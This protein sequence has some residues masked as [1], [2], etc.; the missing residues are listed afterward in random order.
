MVLKQKR[1]KQ[2][3]YINH[4]QIGDSHQM[5]DKR[6]LNLHGDGYNDSESQSTDDSSSLTELS[7]LSVL[8]MNRD[9]LSKI[10]YDA[11]I[12]IF[13]QKKRSELI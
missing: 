11:I 12:D 6:T 13:A 1:L 4:L 3:F 10:Y 8:L 9:Y 7:D 2:M 5:N